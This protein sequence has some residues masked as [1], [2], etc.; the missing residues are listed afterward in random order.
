M[1]AESHQTISSG[2]SKTYSLISHSPSKQMLSHED[3]CLKVCLFEEPKCGE[4]M[5]S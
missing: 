5:V 3:I 2:T 1:D 4:N